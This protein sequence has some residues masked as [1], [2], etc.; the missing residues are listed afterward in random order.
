MF[1]QRSIFLDI[2]A[3]RCSIVVKALCS[4][5]KVAGSRPDELND[6]FQFT[7]SFRPH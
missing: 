6:L 4:S 3:G 5:R 2:V 7:Y 1:M